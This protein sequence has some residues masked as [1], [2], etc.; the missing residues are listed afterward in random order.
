MEGLS[1]QGFGCLG[2]GFF[3][4]AL[5][6]TPYPSS[7]GSDGPLISKCREYKAYIGNLLFSAHTKGPCNYA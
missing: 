1:V 2:F 7:K 3:S 6:L 5:N 4:W